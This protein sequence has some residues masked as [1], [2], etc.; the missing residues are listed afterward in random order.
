MSGPKNLKLLLKEADLYRI[1]G[2]FEASKEK[3]TQAFQFIGKNPQI[4]NQAK[5][6]DA[7]KKRILQLNKDL[8]EVNGAIEEPDLSQDVQ[9]LIKRLFSFSKTQEASLMEGAV[10]LAK[11]GQHEQALKGFEKMM[12]DGILPLMAA[13]NIIRCYMS[14]SS[15][16]AAIS[17]YVKWSS[18]ELLP[19]QDLSTIRSFLEN[20][21]EKEG[22][23]VDLP[24]VGDDAPDFGKGGKKE[25]GFLDI[26][27]VSVSLNE[28][29]SNAGR[30]EFEVCFQTGNVIS[31]LITDHQKHVFDAFKLGRRL[32]D[33]EYFS[34]M[35]VFRGSGTVSGKTQVKQ[36]PNRGNYVLDITMI[37]DGP[38][39]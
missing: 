38:A 25:E 21:L 34:P 39:G 12:E 33:I 15:P 31:L 1:Q 20:V 4:S 14:I 36:G 3:Y 9:N 19:K 37:D 18:R 11:F 2:L 27:S 13:K 26:S 22:I 16:E 30:A 35:A 10:A 8:A 6:M 24:P 5:L 32:N 28:G 17:Q 23:K 7:I 29:D